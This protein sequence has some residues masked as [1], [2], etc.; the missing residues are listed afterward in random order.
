MI[1]LEVGG[2]KGASSWCLGGWQSGPQ[3][4]RKEP[5]GYQEWGSR[6][7]QGQ[8]AGTARASTDSGGNPEVAKKKKIK[9]ADWSTEQRIGARRG[10]RR[11]GDERSGG[12]IC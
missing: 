7:R 9:A 11:V 1:V 4:G 2:R 5:V 10:G 3:T 12:G 8:E 6:Q